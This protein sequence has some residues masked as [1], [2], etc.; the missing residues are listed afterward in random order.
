MPYKSEKIKIQKTKF[1]RRVKLTDDQRAYIRWLREEEQ[2]SYNKLAE[3][4]NV[5][6]RL[7]QFICKPETMM[8]CRENF[9]KRRKDGRY[10]NK[11]KHA[12]Y[13]RDTR[14]Y[15]QQLFLEGKIDFR[16]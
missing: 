13:I 8:K 3:K 14:K 6:K 4:F 10:Y 1:D 9:K 2:L 5:S 16:L 11:E 7:I 12:E 15:K